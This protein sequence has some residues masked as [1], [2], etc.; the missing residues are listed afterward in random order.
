MQNLLNVKLTPLRT[1]PPRLDFE[2]VYITSKFFNI[3]VEFVSQVGLEVHNKVNELN[4]IMANHISDR[5]IDEVFHHKV[6]TSVD[7]RDV[8]TRLVWYSTSRNR[9]YMNFHFSSHDLNTG[10]FSQLC[11]LKIIVSIN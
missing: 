2:T 6:L 4:L 11:L 1:K 7:S 3:L 5:V 8:N 10:H 9:S